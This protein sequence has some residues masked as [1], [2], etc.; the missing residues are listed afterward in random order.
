M[1]DM[2]G[3]MLDEFRAVANKGAKG[4]DLGIRAEGALEE[5]KHMQLLEPLSI[6]PVTL[7][8]R[9]HLD[10]AAV[11]E[12][13]CDTSLFEEFVHWEPVHASRFKHH[14]IDVSGH[15]PVNQGVEIRSKG[16]ESTNRSRRA[17]RWQGCNDLGRA[18]IQSSRIGMDNCKGLD[19][20]GGG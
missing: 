10:V 9:N 5:P 19:G 12:V 6:I 15:K 14:G 4:T 7:A 2:G 8:A 16:A 11:D 17:V 13:G 18:N 1:E 20:A 3:T